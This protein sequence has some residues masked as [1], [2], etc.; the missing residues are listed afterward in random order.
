MKNILL[1]IPTLSLLGQGVNNSGNIVPLFKASLGGKA[2][3]YLWATKKARA[4]LEFGGKGSTALSDSHTFVR[5]FGL[6]P[7]IM[8]ILLHINV[9]ILTYYVNIQ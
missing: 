1:Y 5:S 2:V 9:M 3:V 4:N 7:S 6:Y 8:S